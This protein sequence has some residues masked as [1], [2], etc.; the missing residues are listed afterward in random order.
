[1]AAAGSAYEMKR[2]ES[3]GFRGRR[4]VAWSWSRWRAPRISLCMARE[5]RLAIIP[6][7]ERNRDELIGVKDSRKEVTT[8]DLFLVGGSQGVWRWR[9]CDRTHPR[10]DLTAGSI[11]A[12]KQDG[13]GSTYG[14]DT[15]WIHIDARRCMDRHHRRAS[16]KTTT[17][18]RN[19][20]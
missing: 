8:H 13:T 9:V 15:A 2:F 19:P 11:Q 17:Q 12:N 4:S 3:K 5:T 7:L 18:R 20:S 16:V 6:V 14:C 10:G 1:M